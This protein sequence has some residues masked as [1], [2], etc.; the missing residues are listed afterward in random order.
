MRK[1]MMQAFHDV[2]NNEVVKS[3]QH[4]GAA[5]AIVFIKNNVAHCA[6]VGNVRVVLEHEGQVVFYTKDHTPDRADEYVRIEDKKGVEF[7]D[8][9]KEFLILSRSVGDHGFNKDIIL[10]EPDYEEIEL[11]QEYKF[12]ILATDG[13]W[14]VTTEE[15]VAKKLHAEQSKEQDVNALAKMLC[16]FAVEKNSKDNITVML[17][18][19]LS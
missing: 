18:D 3:N 7:V 17:V 13:L 8:K 14:R 1:R 4:C 15:E 11:N 6:H 12:L 5:A 9:M 2:D 16:D 19:L 10:A